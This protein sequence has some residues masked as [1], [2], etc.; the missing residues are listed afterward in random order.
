MMMKATELGSLAETGE[1]KEEEEGK[2]KLNQ[3]KGGKSITFY[4]ESLN[5]LLKQTDYVND[6]NF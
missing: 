6:R 2:R 1:W 4:T 3:N 5:Q